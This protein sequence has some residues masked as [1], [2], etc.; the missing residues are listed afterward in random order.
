[1]PEIK[2][3]VISPDVGGSFG[4]EVNNAK[5]HRRPVP[6]SRPAETETRRG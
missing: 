4:M 5:S 6:A 1:M 2:L 3:R